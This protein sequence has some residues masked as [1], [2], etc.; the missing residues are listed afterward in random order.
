MRNIVLR[1]TL[2]LSVVSSM[3]FTVGIAYGI[4]TGDKTLMIMSLIICIVNIYKIW[5]LKRIEKKN[6]YIII[7]CLFDL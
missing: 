2:I 3:C 1:R 4:T 5:D 7:Q 6:K